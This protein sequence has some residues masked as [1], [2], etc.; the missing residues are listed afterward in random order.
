MRIMLDLVHLVFNRE[1]TM[2]LI[3][4]I[5]QNGPR[6]FA[7]PLKVIPFGPQRAIAQKVFQSIFAEALQEG[8]FDFLQQQW[9]CIEIED[10]DLRWYFSVDS[11]RQMLIEK[12]GSNQATIKGN[13]KAFLQL[14]SRQKDPDTLF[15]QRRLMI[16]GDTD[17]CHGVKNLLDG[18]ELGEKGLRLQRGLTSLNALVNPDSPVN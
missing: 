3:D 1:K 14:A 2:S 4:I 6:L 12:Q 15:F 13:W 10:L 9:L 7:L 16:I 8:D 18:I 5:K 11:H 17:L